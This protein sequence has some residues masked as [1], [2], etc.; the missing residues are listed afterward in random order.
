V[1]ITSSSM[2]AAYIL[3]KHYFNDFQNQQ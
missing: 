1:F 3:V 2:K